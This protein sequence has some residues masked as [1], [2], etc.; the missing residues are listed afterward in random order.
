MTVTQLECEQH[1]DEI[2]EKIATHVRT[3]TSDRIQETRESRAVFRFWMSL[4]ISIVFAIS[5]TLTAFVIKIKVDTEIHAIKIDNNFKAIEE[6][7]AK[8]DRLE[9]TVNKAMGDK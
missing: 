2:N 7:G 6:I 9:S 8:I 3:C 5:C 4:C 1:R